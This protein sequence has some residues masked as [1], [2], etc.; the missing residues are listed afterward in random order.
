MTTSRSALQKLKMLVWPPRPDPAKS[1][2]IAEVRLAVASLFAMAVFVA[3]AGRIFMLAMDEDNRTN[4][5]AA[6]TPDV[7]RGRIL[8]RDG[9]LLAVNLPITVM[10]ADPSEIMDVTEAARLLAPHIR[11]YDEASLQKL[12]RKKTR[13]VELDRKVTPAR[14]AEIL[15]LGIPGVYFSD[16]NLRA[17]PRG[18]AAAHILGY[19]DPDNNGLAGVEKS[20]DAILATGQ[21]VTLS[22]DAGIQNIVATEIAKQINEFEAIGGAG[23]M[24]DALTGEIMALVSLPDYNPNHYGVAIDDAKFNRATKGLYEM[25]STFKVLNTAISLESGLTNARTR[26]EVAKP[27]RVGGHSIR[28]YPPFKRPLNVAEILIYS[29]NIGSA[30][31]ADQIGPEVQRAYLDKLG[32]L[33]RLP[34]ELPEIAHPLVPRRWKRTETMTVSYGHGISISPAHLASAVG[35]ASANGFWIAPT[36]LRRDPQVNLVKHRVFSDETARAVRSMMRMVV[37][38]VDGTGNFAEAKGYMVGGKT[39]TAEK[40]VVGGYD[41]NLNL[42]TFV[43]T[44]PVHD[45]RYVTV[46]MIDAPQGQKQSYG[47]ATG[48]W[49]AAPAVRRIVEQ[50]APLLN[51]LPV[52]ENSPEIRQKLD[53]NFTIGNEEATLVSF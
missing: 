50:A 18:N 23:V 20:M 19:V 22:I 21:D 2:R 30:H 53:L 45:P 33:D 35:A 36:L 46:I 9:Q 41:K 38:H 39:G 31:M 8:D 37:A 13:Y 29:S 14:H 24:L 4:R 49:V 43:A 51:I 1:R 5:V 10:H 25:G 3:I 32:L 15:Q 48:G 16:G 42:A 34:L 52:D 17:Y 40:V 12:L 28:D 26:Y 11:R 44:F 27:I 6:N 47:Y 7:E